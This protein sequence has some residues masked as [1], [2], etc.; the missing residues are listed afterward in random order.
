MLTGYS[1][2]HWHAIVFLLI[3]LPRRPWS[4]IVER[5]WEAL[6]SQ[7]LI[8][9]QSHMNKN[10]LVLVPLRKLMAKAK[11][12]R[13]SELERLRNDPQAAGR[14]EMEDEN[15]PIP[16]SLGR[17]SA[18]SNVPEIFRQRWRQLLVNFVEAPHQVEHSP[19]CPIHTD[20]CGQSTTSSLNLGDL[21]FDSTFEPANFGSSALGRSQVYPRNPSPKLQYST[22]A[23]NFGS[24]AAESNS[25]STI[26]DH[27]TDWTMNASFV[28]WLWSDTGSSADVFGSLDANMDL[29]NDV[30][31]YN[32]IQ[33]TL[34]VETG[35]GPDVN[36]AA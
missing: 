20:P 32:W 17:F 34:A 16:K 26:S 7:W 33:S 28:P 12:Y 3:E 35:S 21:G 27:P 5:A 13:N 9:A 14:L 10:L 22:T 23:D 24:F 6:H 29:D 15:I 4:P 25:Y 1:R 31:W 18:G 11:K 2:S 30:D 19:G 8:P 36:G